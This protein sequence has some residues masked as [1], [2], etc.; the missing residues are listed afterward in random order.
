MKGLDGEWRDRSQK[1]RFLKVYD[2]ELNIKWCLYAQSQI[3]E[4]K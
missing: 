1:H 4:I 2:K 3:E